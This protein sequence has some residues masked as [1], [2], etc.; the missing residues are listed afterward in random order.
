MTSYSRKAT[1]RFKVA[2]W[3]EQA[4]V[5]IDGAGVTM[6]EAYIP[7]RGLTHAECSYTYEGEIEGT[8]TSWMLCA[9]APGEPATFEGYA[10]LTGAIAGQEGTCVW[11]IT[12]TYTE[13]EGVRQHLEIVAGLG[14]GG[15][16][17]IKGESDLA[18]PTDAPDGYEMVLAYDLG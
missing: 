16:E 6:G 1:G 13:A 18:L 4:N 3:K 2:G 17:G 5:D 9:Y 11:R 10:Q 12:G 8:V 15:L 14:T 7:T